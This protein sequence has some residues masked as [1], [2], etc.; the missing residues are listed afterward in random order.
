MFWH[1]SDAE[2]AM[3]MLIEAQDPQSEPFREHVLGVGHIAK[4]HADSCYYEKL[5]EPTQTIFR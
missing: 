2:M 4:S 3:T 5:L 1:R